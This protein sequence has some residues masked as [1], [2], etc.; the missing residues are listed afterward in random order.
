MPKR[1]EDRRILVVEDEALVAMLLDDMLGALGYGVAGP[2]GTLDAALAAVER[3]PPDAALL[4]INLHGRTVYSVAEALAARAIPFAFVTGYDR[5]GV[6]A[7]WRDHPMLEKPFRQAA[8][9]R[10]LDELLD[11]RARAAKPR[12]RDG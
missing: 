8:L 5:S 4:D 2:V 9:G 6:S 1:T 7:A 10:L 3:E 11:G 12:P